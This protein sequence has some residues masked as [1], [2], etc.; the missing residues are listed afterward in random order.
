MVLLSTN[1]TAADGRYSPGN[2]M[3][4]RAV[5]NQMEMMRERD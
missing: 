2:K 4:T 1:R 3:G 5:W